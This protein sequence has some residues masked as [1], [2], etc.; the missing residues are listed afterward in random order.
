MTLASAPRT[1][2]IAH[3]RKLDRKPQPIVGPAVVLCQG[4]VFGRQRIASLG[5]LMSFRRLEQRG[6]RHR[7]Q[8]RRR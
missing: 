4:D 2:Q 5:V 6:T 8:Q 3:K 7:V 1:A